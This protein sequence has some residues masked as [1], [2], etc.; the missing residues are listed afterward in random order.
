MREF[1]PHSPLFEFRSGGSLSRGY[2]SLSGGRWGGK[3]N[4]S[5]CHQA[6]CPYV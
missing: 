6:N 3:L 2:S 1:P 4:G 5:I